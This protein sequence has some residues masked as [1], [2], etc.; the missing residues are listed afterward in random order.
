MNADFENLNDKYLYHLGGIS[1]FILVVGYLLT[2]P[3]YA[4][5]GDAPPGNV[6]EQLAYFAEHD[7]GWWA[8]LG[9]M[10]FTDLL[11]IPIFMALYQ[12]LQHID[13]TFMVLA[14]A[15]IGLFIVLDLSLTWTSYSA[16]IMSGSLY[17]SAISE[18]EK[19]ALVARAGYPSTMLASPLLGTYAILIPSLGF[20]FTG[21]VMQKGVFS[22]AAAGL[23]LA[24]GVTA[25]VFMGSYYWEPLAIFRIINA[26]FATAWYIVVGWQLYRLSR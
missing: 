12:A 7:A 15:M 1:A 16:L 14:C 13:Q 26:L 22:K 11:Y 21:L 19:A 24:V 23:A 2:F 9:L 6:E 18:V 5:V 8:I 17:A 25:F 20:L 3:I 10:V 4:W